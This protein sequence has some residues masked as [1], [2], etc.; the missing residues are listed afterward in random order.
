MKIETTERGFIRGD[1]LDRY[2]A[3]CSI[4]ESSLAEE[5]CIWLGCDHE[6]IHHVTGEPCGARMHLTQAMAAELIPLLQ[7]FVETGR[8]QR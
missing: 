1:F 3:A 7:V 8:L 2:K 5:D 4:Q 6:T